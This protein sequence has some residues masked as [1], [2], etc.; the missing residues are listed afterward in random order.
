M[1]RERIT[2]NIFVFRS[3]KYAQVTC[4]LVLTEAGAVL[5]DTL[6]YPDETRRI[7]RY[8]E[9]GLG[10][11]VVCLICTHFH[12]D[13][14]TGACFFPDAQVVA[15]RLCRALL[16]TRGRESLRQLKSTGSEFDGISIALP[17]ITFDQ[18]MALTIGG[19][20]F[21]LWHAPGHS[22]DLICVLQMNEEILFASDAV[23]PMPFFADGDFDDCRRSL[24]R[25]GG[26]EYE[27]IVQGHGDI[28]LR[29]EQA[30][31]LESDLA[32]LDRL[33]DAVARSD[34]K[35]RDAILRLIT[36][37]SCGKSGAILNGAAAQLHEQNLRHMLKRRQAQLA[38][39]PYQA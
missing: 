22:P 5:I 26:R 20:D 3:E 30:E 32:Y 24:Q 17:D 2:E 4:G 15:H 8:I 11:H 29:G 27:N 36:P 23:L 37:E 19:A 35:E 6:L 31:R 7:Q 14:S 33:E 10:Q 18:E 9:R 1:Q 16:D 39:M 34:A 21:R 38:A 13:H 25:L 12:A 28:I